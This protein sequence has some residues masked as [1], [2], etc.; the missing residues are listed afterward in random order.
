CLARGVR[1][2][3]Q[4]HRRADGDHLQHESID[5][6]RRNGRAPSRY[7]LIPGSLKLHAGDQTPRAKPRQYAC[8][9]DISP[10]FQGTRACTRTFND[11]N[12]GDSTM[13]I[14]IIVSAL[15]LTVAFA[16][17]ASATDSGAVGGAVTG[18]VA[19]AVVGGPVGAVVGAGVGGVV[20]NEVT[21]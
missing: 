15:A 17:P 6:E 21:G 1:C 3:G 2:E 16:A 19:G 10:P 13:R 4:V 14:P 11:Y 9:R 20:G 7:S 5:N 12:R 8:Q 18:G